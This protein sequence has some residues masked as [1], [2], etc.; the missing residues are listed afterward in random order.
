[1]E[2][3]VYFAEVKECMSSLRSFV[4]IAISDELNKAMQMNDIKL[5]HSNNVASNIPG[6]KKSSAI[7][8]PDSHILYDQSGNMSTIEKISM[9]G[10]NHEKTVDANFHSNSSID[11]DKNKSVF[12]DILYQE[13]LSPLRSNNASTI[14]NHYNSERGDN[15]GEFVNPSI[16][17]KTVA[18]FLVQENNFVSIDDYLLAI[19][20]YI[21]LIPLLKPQ[22]DLQ[23][24]NEPVLFE[25]YSFIQ[26]IEKMQSIVDQ[27]RKRGKV[28]VGGTSM[29]R[30]PLSQVDSGFTFNKEIPS[31]AIKLSEVERIFADFKL[32]ALTAV[33]QLS[34]AKLQQESALLQLEDSR[35]KILEMDY[36]LLE[37]TRSYESSIAAKDEEIAILSDEKSQC[38]VD[39]LLNQ[40]L[41]QE[42]RQE[43]LSIQEFTKSAV[44]S[45]K[46]AYEKEITT[47]QHS[48]SEHIDRIQDLDRE[49][50]GQAVS[51]E[52]MRFNMQRAL[53]LGMF[54]IEDDRSAF[55][56]AMESSS[57]L[58]QE[59]EQQSAVQLSKARDM[60]ALLMHKNTALQSELS[61]CNNLLS[62]FPIEL[63]SVESKYK[64]IISAVEDKLWASLEENIRFQQE[65]AEANRTR[66]L[67]EIQLNTFYREKE[68]SDSMLR[69]LKSDYENL[70]LHVQMYQERLCLSSEDARSC[71]YES[72]CQ[73]S[74]MKE[75]LMKLTAKM[76]TQLD[77][78]ECSAQSSD[79]MQQ[80][81]Q[82]I[83]KSLQTEVY[84]LEA[85]K[86]SLQSMLR[87]SHTKLEVLAR[88][89]D[90]G[91]KNIIQ[92]YYENIQTYK[93]AV[94]VVNE[95]N[96]FLR[97]KM[98]DL[99][100]ETSSLDD[101]SGSYDWM[102]NPMKLREHASSDIS[103]P[104]PPPSRQSELEQLIFAYDHLIRQLNIGDEEI[105]RDALVIILNN[106][107][108]LQVAD[109]EGQEY[110]ALEENELLRQTN[111]QL[112]LEIDR[113][114]CFHTAEIG[115]LSTMFEVEMKVVRD[116]LQSLLACVKNMKAQSI[117]QRNAFDSEKSAL[118]L[119]LSDA[120][121]QLFSTR[122]EK[123]AM[124]NKF[125]F[126]VENLK[127]RYEDILSRVGCS[128]GANL[129]GERE[130]VAEIENNF[131]LLLSSPST[132]AIPQRAIHLFAELLFVSKQRLSSPSRVYAIDSIPRL[133]FAQSFF[134]LNQPNNYFET[135]S[136]TVDEK[137][138]LHHEGDMIDNAAVSADVIPE[139]TVSNLC[140]TLEMTLGEVYRI[141]HSHHLAASDAQSSSMN[142]LVSS[143]E[144]SLSV[145]D[146]ALMPMNSIA[147][148]L[149]SE[150]RRFVQ[151][152]VVAAESN[153]TRGSWNKQVESLGMEQ[154]HALVVS[155]VAVTGDVIRKESRDQSTQSSS[156]ENAGDDDRIAAVRKVC[157]ENKRLKRLCS[158]QQICI[159]AL[160]L[161]AL[162]RRGLV[163]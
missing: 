69:I 27:C 52:A 15:D 145:Q 23:S 114:K 154:S 136:N 98:E 79:Y 25:E 29:E 80:R 146:H 131:S 133:Q 21:S 106:K 4:G 22:I 17:I 126:V 135:L 8:T 94:S 46:S 71:R 72:V 89:K 61:E 10:Y 76:V 39:L 24:D 134:L 36:K 100:S 57:K 43:L 74:A 162:E 105:E 118:E 157:R 33:E 51:A 37:N 5:L 59:S 147:A 107:F 155:T 32:S 85:D 34:T 65:I 68:D 84:S 120:E 109:L 156:A 141:I 9:P 47:L 88:A 14:H 108:Q 16:R 153:T 92:N 38:E 13:T 64:S 2:K 148:N 163:C 119:V 18:P 97:G 67:L 115:R 138:L 151:R 1:M 83:I 70:S 116:K 150:L 75:K 161:Q 90:A 139:D 87:D 81:L 86:Q 99:T 73:L 103:L 66:Q 3:D 113:F 77:A 53:H 26:G 56:R 160:R 35:S 31:L 28:L 144:V 159:M 101:G 20:W 117:E 95:S 60:N 19:R 132:S 48:L 152:L 49:V 96:Q 6:W 11:H 41:L 125:E 110:S 42:S 102:P 63:S 158:S 149:L 142:D 128:Y 58:L 130:I 7:V 45:M 40:Q 122:V 127:M 91:E 93:L 30:N 82:M 121:S 44:L 50:Y 111:N 78:T 143:D 140:A 137:E 112:Q 124:L 54:A 55:L 12:A 62:Q 129:Q 123:Q 104:P